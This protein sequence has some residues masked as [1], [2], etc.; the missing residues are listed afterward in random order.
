VPA[1]PGDVNGLR[2]TGARSSR[3]GEARTGDLWL[4][5]A[6]RDRPPSRAP[7][8]AAR[9]QP[10]R[11]ALLGTGSAAG[12][13]NPWCSCASCRSAREAE[14]DR[15]ATSLL[16]D[17]RLLLDPG[18][19]ALRS[20]ARAGHDLS[21][22]SAVLLTRPL[23]DRGTAALLTRREAGCS[24]PLTVAGPAA[25]LAGLRDAVSPDDPVTL[26]PLE[27][28]DRLVIE[29]YDVAVVN[30]EGTARLSRT[31]YDI[32][33]RSGGRLL[34][35][36]PTAVLADAAAD[37]LDGAE[38]DVALLPCGGTEDEGAPESGLDLF[39]ERLAELRRRG[40]VTGATRVVAVHLDH[41]NPAPAELHRRL[42]LLD[43][44]ALADG[45]LLTTRVPGDAGH[46]PRR[47][48]VLGGARSGKSAEAERR[49]AAEP[50]VTYVATGPTPGADDPD[51][52][53]RVAQHR[54]RRPA[55][56]RTVETTGLAALLAEP[57][58]D[59]PL[60]VDDLGLWLTAAMDWAG[61][62][63]GAAG[64]SAKLA[65][66]VDAL[67]SAWRS[68]PAYV[69]AVSNEVG[70]GVHPE[71]A[72]GRLFRD[73]MGRLNARLAAESDEVWYVV[74]GVAQ[75]LR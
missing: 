12:W 46:D 7:D 54:E 2:G 65:A 36:P 53:A 9:R 24:A 15:G 61:A 52:A 58:D 74:A 55:S 16:V 8:L 30:P 11:V 64:A 67:V 33:S 50:V 34:V 32:T 6:A 45:A 57:P 4:A 69:V 75:R 60:L 27:P 1:P 38:F 25:A 68:T 70:S 29:G 13:P 20:A 44:E 72:A 43:A 49:L 56:W 21:R 22:V 71:T 63:E 73:Q 14:T 26:Q 31:G 59:A 66:A 17:D 41:S 39:A 23:P 19:A 5:R 40:A 28:D 42:G 3:G 47:V 62:W 10:L 48:L 37:A 51:W 18:E 35:L